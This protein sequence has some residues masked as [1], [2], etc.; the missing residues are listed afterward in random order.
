MKKKGF[1]LIELLVVVAIIGVLATVVLG[2][3]GDAR[4]KARNAK[5]QLDIKTIQTALEL[6]YADNGTY[7]V[8]S[9]TSSNYASTWSAFSAQLGLDLPKDPL[10]DPSTGHAYTP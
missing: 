7:P 6:Y 4:G 2:A 8:R 1:T 9:W 10:N 5:R 3:L